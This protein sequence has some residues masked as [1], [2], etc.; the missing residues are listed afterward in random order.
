[1]KYICVR[2]ACGVII[3]LSLSFNFFAFAD[4]DENVEK[5]FNQFVKRSQLFGDILEKGGSDD[6]TNMFDR[7]NDSG[8]S[9]IR[10]TL[11]RV[12]KKTALSD[13]YDRQL[14]AINVSNVDINSYFFESDQAGFINYRIDKTDNLEH[15]MAVFTEYGKTIGGIYGCM[16]FNKK[17]MLTEFT[18]NYDLFLDEGEQPII[19]V[20]KW[21]DNK[22]IVTKKNLN[23]IQKRKVIVP[24]VPHLIQ[25]KFEKSNIDNPPKTFFSFKPVTLPKTNDKKVEAVLRRIEYI[26][27]MKRPS[28]L[29]QLY[30]WERTKESYGGTIQCVN[31]KVRDIIFTAPYNYNGF[32]FDN[33]YYVSIDDNGKISAYAEGINDSL[34]ERTFENFYNN[35][36]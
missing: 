27:N 6:L 30:K 33:G 2:V 22:N 4:E 10:I 23:F 9:I 29:A 28:D 17:G 26:A 16:Q 19:S 15:I 36:G 1:M 12:N 21:D 18:I 7:P 20:I 31:G 24:P 8:N 34:E 14:Y 3:F 35:Q 13:G 32:T 5:I 25:E 11:D